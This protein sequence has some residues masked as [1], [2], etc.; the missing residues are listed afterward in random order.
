M[1]A[2]PQLA[3]EKDLL[4]RQALARRKAMS[5]VERI[6]KSLLLADYADGLPIADS[7]VVA[8]FW[9]IREEIDPR[10]LLDC[11]RQKGHTL[12]LP[13]VAEPYLVFRK[14]ERDADLVPVGFGTMAPG[15]AAQAVR[16]DVL[17]MPLAGFDNAGNRI[18][19]GKGHYDKVI[20]ALE[21]TGPLLCIGLAFSEQEVDRVPVEAHDKPL[22]G[23]LTEQGYRAFG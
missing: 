18:G 21:E 6:E 13:V 9:P 15:P 20:T 23:I 8:G 5:D 16:P 7:A 22:N 2:I 12:C 19:Y 17:L 10:P 3:A 14:L 1:T 4:R 11:L